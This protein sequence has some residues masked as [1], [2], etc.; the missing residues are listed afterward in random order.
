MIRKSGDELYNNNVH[1]ESDFSKSLA[2]VIQDSIPVNKFDND[3]VNHSLGTVKEL[4][5]STPKLDGNGILLQPHQA[6]LRRRQMVAGME[7]TV[8]FLFNPSVHMFR[9]QAKAILVCQP[10]HSQS[11][12]FFFP[13]LLLR[14]C[15]FCVHRHGKFAVRRMGCRFSLLL[16]WFL[17][18]FWTV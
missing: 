17:L 11:A 10:Y 18:L 8:I 14:T 3:Q 4:I 12:L 2:K 13:V 6:R 7:L 16:A 5:E 15:S 1:H 9:L